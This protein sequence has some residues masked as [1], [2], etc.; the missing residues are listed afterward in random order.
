ME[1]FLN[2][3]LYEETIRNFKAAYLGQCKTNCIKNNFYFGYGEVYNTKCN[4]LCDRRYD[5]YLELYYSI[6]KDLP[7]KI[8]ACIE[9]Y[10]SYDDDQIQMKSCIFDLQKLALDRLYKKIDGLQ[11]Y[12]S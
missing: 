2:A 7:P 4:K 5:E 12:L 6:Q 11:I 3:V 9:K 10:E 1:K 8:E